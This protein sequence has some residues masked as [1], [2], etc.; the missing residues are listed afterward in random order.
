MKDS[1]I[2]MLLTTKGKSYLRLD[3][4]QLIDLAVELQTTKKPVPLV[5]TEEI[6]YVVGYL[7]QGHNFNEYPRVIMVS[8]KEEEK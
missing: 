2:V 7:I 4:N 3:K 6:F 8:P 5:T 1:F